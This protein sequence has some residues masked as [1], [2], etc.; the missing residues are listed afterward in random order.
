[1]KAVTSKVITDLISTNESV[2]YNA[3]QEIITKTNYSDLKP[4]MYSI[5]SNGIK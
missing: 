3:Y 4:L 5:K 1:M 2:R